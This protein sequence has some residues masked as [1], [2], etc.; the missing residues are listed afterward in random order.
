MVITREIS[1]TGWGWWSCHHFCHEVV[2]VIITIVWIP[3]PLI[4]GYLILVNITNMR[5]PLSLSSS[6]L[7]VFHNLCHHNYCLDSIITIIISVITK[8]SLTTTMMKGNLSNPILQDIFHFLSTAGERL[9][10]R[11]LGM[12]FNLKM[13]ETLTKNRP[14]PNIAKLFID[15]TLKSKSSHDCRI[16]LNWLL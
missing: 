6:L 1:N 2:F 11:W 12:D 10:V 8:R 13:K 15:F 16:S 7:W 9:Q 14:L 3:S 4:W 5:I